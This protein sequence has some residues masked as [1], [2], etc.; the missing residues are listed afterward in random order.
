MDLITKE[1]LIMRYRAALVQSA[2]L[3]RHPAIRHGITGRIPGVE[4]AEAN[5]GYSAP[6]DRD[7][8]WR[9]RQRWARAA[10]IDPLA[11]STAHQVHGRE[12]IGVGVDR[13]GHGGPLGS[14]SLGKADAVMTNTPGVAVM[15]LHADC[16]PII[17]AD[18][19]VSAVAAVHAG[20]RGTV[21]DIVGA[22]V[23]AMASEYGA[24]PARMI[25]LMGPGMRS[26]CYEVGDEV[27]A[28]W[29]S[30]AGPEGEPALSRGP[31]RWHF[32]LSIANRL[33]LAQAGIDAARIDDQSHCTQCNGDRWF[34]HRLQGSETGRFGAMAGIVPVSAEEA[35]SWV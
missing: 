2:L 9:E 16:L 1:D 28:A 17:V 15:T 11:I 24:K 13:R 32:D 33:L 22:T 25:V 20:W 6:R 21:A 35:E 30:A 3:T 14:T 23:A 18:L 29:R 31:R 34:S 26:C 27:V 10:G 4:P 12:V 19:E 7:A 8:A 5:I